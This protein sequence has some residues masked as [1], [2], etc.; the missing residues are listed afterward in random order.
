[1]RQSIMGASTKKMEL[2]SKLIDITSL[3]SVYADQRK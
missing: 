2:F 3:M 1:M